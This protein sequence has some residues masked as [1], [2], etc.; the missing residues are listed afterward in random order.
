MKY[1]IQ[2]N[3]NIFPGFYN[4]FLDP[5]NIDFEGYELNY[6]DFDFNIYKNEI[7]SAIVDH[8][9]RHINTNISYNLISPKSY[10]YCNDKLDITIDL[11]PEQI[12]KLCFE[13]EEK[14]EIFTQFCDAEHS[15]NCYIS[16]LLNEFFYFEA[17]IEDEDWMDIMI[18]ALFN[19][20][21]NNTEI[22]NTEV[23]DEETDLTTVED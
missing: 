14:Y 20:M 21:K 15:D 23:N 17:Y 7:A 6:D 9:N 2:L 18:E 5:D 22:D 3:Q 11:E 10:N 19:S 12:L 13:H 4:T 8:L 1:T 16:D